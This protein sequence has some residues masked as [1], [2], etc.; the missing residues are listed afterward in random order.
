M[1][2]CVAITAK[3]TAI[4][5]TTAAKNHALHTYIVSVWE[6]LSNRCHSP[7]CDDIMCNYKYWI[8]IENLSLPRRL[9]FFWSVCSLFSSKTLERMEK[10]TGIQSFDTDEW[11]LH[12]PINMILHSIWRR[13]LVKSRSCM[14]EEGRRAKNTRSVSIAE[15]TKWGWITVQV[16]TQRHHT[17]NAYT[18]PVQWINSIIIGFWYNG[19]ATYPLMKWE[20]KTVVMENRDFVIIWPIKCCWMFMTVFS[21]PQQKLSG[22]LSSSSKNW[23][24]TIKSGEVAC[25]YLLGIFSSMS[26]VVKSM[27]NYW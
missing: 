12:Y 15:E 2:E 23:I 19:E 26:L 11:E 20:K 24:W 22:R 21:S 5:T 1:I 25:C 8:S 7:S 18:N 3:Q 9:L 10:K 13:Y 27:Q 6:A 14:G 16:H 4:T 17:K